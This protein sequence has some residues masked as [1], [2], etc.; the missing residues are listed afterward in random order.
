MLQMCKI[1]FLILLSFKALMWM[2]VPVAAEACWRVATV[3]GKEATGSKPVLRGQA[4]TG[5]T[6]PLAVRQLSTAVC[7][8][9]LT[10]FRFWQQLA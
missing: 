6:N 1:G 4:G 2:E 9:H 3:V 10:S 7:R 8:L 5:S